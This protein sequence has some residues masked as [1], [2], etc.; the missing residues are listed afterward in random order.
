M[1]TKCYI[2][3]KWPR[4]NKD[5]IIVLR[6]LSGMVQLAIKIHFCSLLLLAGKF[7]VA[8]RDNIVNPW[9]KI[10]AAVLVMIIAIIHNRMLHSSLWI[11]QLRVTMKG[12]RSKSPT[13]SEQSINLLQ[14]HISKLGMHLSNSAYPRDIAARTKFLIFSQPNWEYKSSDSKNQQFFEWMSIFN[15]KAIYTQYEARCNKI[16]IVVNA[17][18]K[19][20][21]V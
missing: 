13:L 17:K 18:L 15:D 2:L 10:T 21:K 5:L 1:L 9:Y 16:Y 7:H 4:G 14:G 12:A 3:H 20:R 11:H 19:E 6:K 8:D